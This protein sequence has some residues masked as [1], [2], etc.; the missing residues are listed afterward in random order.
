MTCSDCGRSFPVLKLYGVKFADIYWHHGNESKRVE[1]ASKRVNRV[2]RNIVWCFG[3]YTIRHSTIR[4]SENSLFRCDGTP[5]SN[6]GSNVYL[7]T[8]QGAFDH[9]M[10]L[11]E[12][13]HVFGPAPPISALRVSVRVISSFASGKSPVLEAHE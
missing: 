5:L 9:F 4:A 13:A 8:T 3:G 10:R 12:G 7:I 6:L 2:I 11:A 1:N